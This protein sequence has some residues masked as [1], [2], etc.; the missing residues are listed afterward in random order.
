MSVRSNT[1]TEPERTKGVLEECLTSS[2]SSGPESQNGRR[3]QLPEAIVEDVMNVLKY[4][5]ESVSV[6]I[7]EVKPEDWANKVYK[8]DIQDKWDKLYKK[9]GYELSDL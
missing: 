6:P 9:P 3:A 5:E 2:L 1:A 7:E 4:G 8:P